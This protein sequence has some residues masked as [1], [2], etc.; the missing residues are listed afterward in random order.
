[1]E[2]S[3]IEEKFDQVLSG[4]FG[5]CHK[6]VEE[7]KQISL[8]RSDDRAQIKRLTEFMRT[9]GETKSGDKEGEVSDFFLDLFSG[10]YAQKKKEFLS[11]GPG[12][13]ASWL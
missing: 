11:L 10:L 2:R 13:P 8:I 9:Y 12:K 1:M 7:K 4:F 6:L 3:E 5:L